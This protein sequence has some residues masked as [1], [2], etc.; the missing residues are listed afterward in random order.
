MASSQ[1]LEP[2]QRPR[3]WHRV[4]E[5]SAAGLR[6]HPSG[7]PAKKTVNRPLIPCTDELVRPT[8]RPVTCTA[9]RIDSR[10]RSM[11]L[12]MHRDPNR[13]GCRPKLRRRLCKYRLGKVPILLPD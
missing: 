9:D 7:S 10:V 12:S 1:V 8:T 2:Q 3:R 5:R 6:S 11:A 4:Q 13:P